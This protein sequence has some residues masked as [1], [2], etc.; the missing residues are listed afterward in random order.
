MESNKT[1]VQVIAVIV[2]GKLI[3]LSI[4][5]E[6]GVCD[7]IANSAYNCTEKHIIVR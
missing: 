1:T 3:L 4:Q 2:F 5:I 6:L 7:T